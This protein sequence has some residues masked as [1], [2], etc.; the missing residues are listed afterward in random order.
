VVGNSYGRYQWLKATQ[1]PGKRLFEGKLLLPVI[2]GSTNPFQNCRL[3]PAWHRGITN[4]L[5]VGE[6][7]LQRTVLV[8]IN[9]A[10]VGQQLI[11]VHSQ[12]SVGLGKANTMAL[13][14]SLLQ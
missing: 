8:A 2:N 7:S 12:V 14:H 5:G 13:H 10:Q 3:L 6:Y 1:L 4:R 11:D 9:D